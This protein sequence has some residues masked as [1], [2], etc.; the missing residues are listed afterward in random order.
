[1][2]DT[3]RLHY[4]PKDLTPEEREF[5]TELGHEV[6]RALAV[7]VAHPEM[8]FPAGSLAG[9]VQKTC[10]KMLTGP[11]AAAAQAR[12]AKL[13]KADVATRRKY[14]GH[15]GEAGSDAQAVAAA[16]KDLGVALKTKL[17]KA[18]NARLVSTTDGRARQPGRIDLES[19]LPSTRVVTGHFSGDVVTQGTNGVGL[20]APEKLEFRWSTTEAGANAGKW[21]LVKKGPPQL[22]APGQTGTRRTGQLLATGNTG[23]PGSIFTIDLP[24]WLPPQPPPKGAEYY[25]VRVAAYKHTPTSQNPLADA[26]QNSLADARRVVTAGDRQVLQVRHPLFL[27]GGQCLDFSSVRTDR[28][29][30]DHRLK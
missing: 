13:L 20:N 18:V 26:R 29:R 30:D 24:K 7:A 1:M 14:F 16:G 10:R 12:A 8:S 17:T 19:L 27:P 5:A 25:E 6:S 9:R 11:K 28:S 2:P 22:I 15:A 21:Q 3:I 23:A 4:T